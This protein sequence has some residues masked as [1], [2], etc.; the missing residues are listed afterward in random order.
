[1]EVTKIVGQRLGRNR[2]EH[3][4]HLD[5]R[6]LHFRDFVD[7]EYIAWLRAKASL[8]SVKPFVDWMAAA[9]KQLGGA[10]NF[11]YMLN[12]ILG[13]CTVS[14]CGHAEQI[15]TA[16]TGEIVTIPDSSILTMYEASG[17]RP[18]NPEDPQSNQTDQGWYI[19]DAL[20]YMETTG[21]VDSK[22]KVHK[23]DTFLAVDPQNLDHVDLA[24]EIGGLVD[25]G[26]MLPVTAQAQNDYW[27]AV[28]G[29]LEGD[30]APGSWGGHSIVVA[31][32]SQTPHTWLG[33]PNPLLL[34]DGVTWGQGDWQLFP[35]FWTLYVD[36]VW[37]P[38]SFDWIEANGTSPSGFNLNALI[39]AANA[40]HQGV[41]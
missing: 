32:R 19:Q 15:W 24:I 2:P 11:G 22:G 8:P 28:A 12:Q 35:N 7:A 29:S 37:M 30:G 25:I 4:P 26:L 5:P 13:C 39:A 17:Y 33:D 14:A 3:P 16:N 1:M 23:I 18:Q 27:Q 41:K 10:G 21:L 20:Q 40:L 9:V 38:V 34:R 36:E 6:V 31:K